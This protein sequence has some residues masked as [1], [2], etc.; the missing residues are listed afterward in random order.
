M[1]YHI[2]V[3]FFSRLSRGGHRPS[4]LDS[5]CCSKRCFFMRKKGRNKPFLY[6]YLHICENVCRKYYIHK[7]CDYNIYKEVMAHEAESSKKRHLTQSAESRADH[8][9]Y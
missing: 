8:H 7:R 9:P 6:R 2:N 5:V 3:P 4:G 1:W